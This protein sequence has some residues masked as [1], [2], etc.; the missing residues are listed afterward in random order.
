MVNQI[1]PDRYADTGFSVKDIAPEVNALYF[2]KIMALSGS[3]RFIM[4]MSMLS[5]AR[6]LVWSGIPQNLSESER[7]RAFYEQ[8]Y[9]KPCPDGVADWR[10][11]KAAPA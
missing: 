1:E 6:A 3:G 11:G 10:P 5:T 8:F 9:G 4:G 2:K 7:R